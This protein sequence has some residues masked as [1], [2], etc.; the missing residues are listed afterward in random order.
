[1]SPIVAIA[2]VNV[3]NYR[4]MGTQYVNALYRCARNLTV[5]FRGQ[6]S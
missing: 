2:A 1:M 4:R 3:G 5:P 6:P